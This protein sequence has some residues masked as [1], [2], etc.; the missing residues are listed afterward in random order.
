MAGYA[1]YDG[2][3]GFNPP[4]QALGNYNQGVASRAV[5]TGAVGGAVPGAA[6]APAAPSA[7]AP[8]P[9]APSNYFSSLGGYSFDPTNNSATLSAAQPSGSTYVPWF[10]YVGQ[11]DATN[12]LVNGKGQFGGL[13]DYQIN[14]LNQKLGGSYAHNIGDA[15]S[16]QADVGSQYMHY[17]RLPGQDNYLGEYASVGGKNYTPDQ[18]DSVVSQWNDYWH[19]A[20]GKGYGNWAPGQGASPQDQANSQALAA[21][22]ANT[23]GDV[24]SQAKQYG[25]FFPKILDP[26]PNS[27]LQ[28]S[29]TP[30]VNG[31]GVRSS[32]RMV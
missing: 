15:W 26:Y 22:H 5:G 10:G 11:D 17:G 1:Y 31:T 24:Y 13:Q 28:N 23:I 2:V 32:T 16:G 19:G 21:A 12:G 14:A 18:Y 25:S 7:T 20:D 9:G 27:I 3:G 29:A 6:A 8:Q 4:G 30:S